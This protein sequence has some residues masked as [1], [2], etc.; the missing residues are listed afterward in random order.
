MNGT[1]LFFFSWFILLYTLWKSNTILVLLKHTPLLRS[2]LWALK[3]IKCMWS[4]P[5]KVFLI[6]NGEKKTINKSQERLQSDLEQLVFLVSLNSLQLYVESLW[7]TESLG[8][9]QVESIMELLKSS[10]CVMETWI[11]CFIFKICSRQ[12]LF[13]CFPRKGTGAILQLLT[14]LST[15]NNY[16]ITICSKLGIRSFWHSSAFM[17]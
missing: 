12:T 3:P 8:F 11:W 14:I 17:F 7:D 5:C 4:N 6:R 13:Y 16:V 1:I 10:P 2:F 9:L 15:L